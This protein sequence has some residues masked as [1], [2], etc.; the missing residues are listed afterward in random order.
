MNILQPLL[1]TAVAA[2]GN[3]AQHFHN[4]F[5][6]R[7]RYSALFAPSAG[8]PWGMMIAPY[9]REFYAA[10]LREPDESAPRFRRRLNEIETQLAEDWP[11]ACQ[12]CAVQETAGLN[13]TQIFGCILAIYL[14]FS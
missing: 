6:A 14:E 8:A 11:A 2:G 5:R 12:S 13:C 1:N 4:L 7:H 9:W 3:I 10:M